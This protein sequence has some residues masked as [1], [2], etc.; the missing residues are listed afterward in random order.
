MVAAETEAYA[1][2][3]GR[4]RGGDPRQFTYLDEFRDQ[5]NS[6]NASVVDVTENIANIAEPIDTALSGI[7]NMFDSLDATMNDI[8]KTMESAMSSGFMSIVDGTQKPI[9]AFKNMARLIIAELYKVLVVKQLV[10]SFDAANPSGATGIV[11]FLGKAFGGFRANGGP[12]S[13]GTPYI[14]G[15]R[16]PELFVPSRSGTIVPN[17]AGGSVTVNQNIS[18]GAGVSRAEI[19][20]MM[21][22]IVEATKAAVMDAKRRGG[23]Y[24]RAMA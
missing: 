13:S 4:G 23:S 5:L 9:E 1:K 12:V 3:V 18:F 14:V 21:P 15:E 17:G 6:V 11:G 22:K 16:G 8:S 24:G 7:D 2:V 19:N 20:A 10:G